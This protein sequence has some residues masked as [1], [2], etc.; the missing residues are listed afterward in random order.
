VAAGAVVTPRKVVRRG[1]LWAGRIENV[2]C[3][4]AEPGGVFRLRRLKR[5]FTHLPRH[6]QDCPGKV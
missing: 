2:C 3:R 1:E 5:H 4:A 6:T